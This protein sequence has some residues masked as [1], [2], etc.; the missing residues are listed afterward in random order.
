MYCNK[1]DSLYT[2]LDQTKE[3]TSRVEILLSII[4][5]TYSIAPDSVIP[6][7]EKLIRVIES[8]INNVD[9]KTQHY[10]LAV[11]ANCYNNIGAIYNKRGDVKNALSFFH[12]SLKIKESLGEKKAISITLN[13]IGYLYS[14]IGDKENSLLYYNRSLKIKK[15]IG[16]KRGIARLLNNLGSL[17]DE[18]G[19]T[20]MSFKSYI[21]SLE[22]CKELN[23]S[24]GMSLAL[25]NIG[26]TY[27]QT[28]NTKKAF[29]YYQKSY[30]IR[31]LLDDQQDQAES[32]N[33]LGNIYLKEGN[34]FKAMELG[35][36]AFAISMKLQYPEYI[37]RSSNLLK[38]V[39][40]KQGNFQKAYQMLALY[41]TMR[42]SIM[43]EEN[44]DAAIKR[45]FEYE[46]ELKTT[47][48]S[49]KNYETKQKEQIA[50]ENEISR[51]RA[52]TYGGIIGFFLML[53]IAVISYKAFQ[54][55]QKAN[56]EITLQKKIIEEKQ[57][58][59]LAS[60]NYAKRIQQS[61]LPTS[62]YIQQS[63]DRLMKKDN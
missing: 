55:K 63:I 50:Y 11:K 51:Q 25:N 6:L 16:D 32:M 35:E 47:A 26:F 58:E 7:S 9:A 41:M 42:D 12:K 39:Y 4:E 31:L 20:A 23:D 28:G 1:I 29:E 56:E 13:N 44:R 5:E 57:K 54:Q 24:S 45:S 21:Q 30:N 38:D 10:F 49:I 8:S 59:V 14:S 15:E 17:Y 27:E 3:D 34:V 53:V 19:D 52:Y 33:N 36:K 40:L 46:Y 48:D 2:L 22:I 37:K 62:K 43:S 60:I 61:I 18:I